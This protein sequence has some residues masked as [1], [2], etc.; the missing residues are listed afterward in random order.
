MYTRRVRCLSPPD[1]AKKHT[2]TYCIMNFVAHS[3]EN[4]SLGFTGILTIGNVKG[5]HK[6]ET[7]EFCDFLYTLTVTL[8][9]C[10]LCI[11]ATTCVTQ[12]M[13]CVLDVALVKYCTLCDHRGCFYF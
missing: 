1:C 5:K 7:N 10:S 2:I 13:Q 9:L 8:C 4:G 11:D 3:K 12:I 6:I